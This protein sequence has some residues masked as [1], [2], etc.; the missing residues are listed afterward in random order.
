[1]K[2]AKVIFSEVS[3]CPQEGPLSLSRGVSIQGGLCPG[4]GSLFRRFSVKGSL[5]RK[6]S[7]WGDLCPGG[8]GLY[9]GESLSMGV[10][11]QMVPVQG[12]SEGSLSKVGSLSRGVSVQGVSVQGSLRGL[13]PQRVLC[14]G[15]L[16]Q[17]VSIQGGLCHG[18]PRTVTSGWYASHWNAFLFVLYDFCV[19]HTQRKRHTRFRSHDALLRVSL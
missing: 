6:V 2:F 16:C 18:N 9:V 8:G 5:S 10:S 19:I 3:I 12:V 7:V 17:G 13:C 4:E 14:W 15:G 1:M 11:V